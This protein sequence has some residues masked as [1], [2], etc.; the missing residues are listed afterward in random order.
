MHNIAKDL[1]IDSKAIL[2]KC[3]AEGIPKIETHMSVVSAGLEATI[4]E[5]FSAGAHNTSVETAEKVDLDKVKAKARRARGKKEGEEEGTPTS[6]DAIS[7]SMT[8]LAEPPRRAGR[9]PGSMSPVE[10]PSPETIVEIL[11][12]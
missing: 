1:G 12:S 3:Q 8:A 10:I 6:P 4:K 5:W 7:E 11:I 2:A 9:K